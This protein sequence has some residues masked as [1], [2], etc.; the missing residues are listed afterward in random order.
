MMYPFSYSIESAPTEE[1]RYT[2]CN[3]FEMAVWF[4]DAKSQA[5]RWPWQRPSRFR[6]VY[7]M[8]SLSLDSVPLFVGEN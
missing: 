1:N 6:C 8:V 7:S 5:I 4:I 2:L 3:C